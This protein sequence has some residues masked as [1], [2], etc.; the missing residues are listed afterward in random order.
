MRNTRIVT[1]A[2]A[3][4]ILVLS[5]GLLVVSCEKAA[6]PGSAGQ[7]EAAGTPRAA[8]ASKTAAVRPSTLGAATMAPAEAALYMSTFNLA[9]RCTRFWRSNAVQSLVRLPIV[10]QLWMQFAMSP[11]YARLM[12]VSG[13]EPSL[14][15]ALPLVEDAL[16][17]E[18][19]LWAGPQVTGCIQGL[20]TVY[21]SAQFANLGAG[22][23]ADPRRLLEAVVAAIVR[24]R[25][26][27]KVPPTV[28]G[29][30]LSKVQ[31][32]KTYLDT[33]LPK[34]GPALQGKL[35]RKTIGNATFYTVELHGTDV[36]REAFRDL[37]REVGTESPLIDWIKEQRLHL[38]L[39][40][41][42]GYLMLAAGP[43]ASVL[44]RWG[45]GPALA[46]SAAFAP[47]RKRLKPGLTDVSYISQAFMTAMSWTAEDLRGMG[48]AVLASIPEA[49]MP[50]GL[51]AR[52]GKD[53]GN[54]IDG[55][56]PLLRPA[57]AQLTFAFE[58]RGIE[59]Y[60]I[61]PE[62]P[63]WYDCSKPLS[64]LGHRGRNPMLVQASRGAKGSLHY[65]LI[66]DIVTIIVR[67]VDEYA[68]PTMGRREKV[69]Y[70]R[71]MK[72]LRPFA[73]AVDTATREHL[74]PAIDGIQSSL[75][76]DGGA[77]LVRLPI[78]NGGAWE[79]LPA[80]IPIPRIAV[81][82]EL[83]DVEQFARA[84]RGYSRAG[85]RLL[86]GLKNEPGIPRELKSFRFPPYRTREVAG[87]TLYYYDWP[88]PQL[89]TGVF[90]C[91]LLK[92]RNLVVATSP[93]LAGELVGQTPLSR[94]AVTDVTVPAGVVTL[95]DFTAMWS[96]LQ[97]LTNS[98]IMLVNR[99]GGGDPRSLMMVGTHLQMLV[100]SL[101]AL[102]SYTSVTT[103]DG[104][105][106]V[107]HSYLHVE[108]I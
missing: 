106:T 2:F 15:Q 90:P 80:P 37:A 40:V 76:I 49:G 27:L 3:A 62:K 36:P 33:W 96:Y 12:H 17:H 50:R 72:L 97:P 55:V 53:M 89:G 93:N 92:G 54:F 1:G 29:F 60:S 32:A 8:A 42:D 19:F 35:E 104:T 77:T 78:G 69:E 108:D 85:M 23:N 81:V 83:N 82:A 22:G 59:S 99:Q 73:A 103:Y 47:L 86:E 87:G 30:K 21:G 57:G 95:I 39:G 107:T 100:R 67:Y 46:D 75:V 105:Q 10:Q 65:D 28:L 6:E 74:V 41:K 61:A 13:T 14:V 45:S 31:A 48:E 56:A 24:E 64:I 9:D 66:A 44:D 7:A 101:G 58:H 26:N 84:V 68:V 70:Q 71:V 102:K 25:E 20:F 4:C 52:L 18:V 43:D 34:L 88:W 91:A 51:K 63:M 98:I 16:S 11:T 38:A 5:T 79:P 94:G